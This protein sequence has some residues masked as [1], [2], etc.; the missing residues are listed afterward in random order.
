MNGVAETVVYEYAG[1]A[2]LG[3]FSLPVF[4]LHRGFVCEYLGVR[5]AGCD[6]GLADSVRDA[7]YARVDQFYRVAL[8][9]GGA[10]PAAV[11]IDAV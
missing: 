11:V 3:G 1:G 10:A 4:Y 2:Q 5:G 7:A 9:K 8:G 6:D